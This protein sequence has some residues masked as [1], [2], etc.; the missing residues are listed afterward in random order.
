V[1]DAALAACR[2]FAA[3]QAP[4]PYAPRVPPVSRVLSEY[5]QS[6]GLASKPLVSREDLTSL[7][8]VGSPPASP[9]HYFLRAAVLHHGNDADHGHYRCV[10]RQGLDCW[11]LADDAVVTALGAFP[12]QLVAEEAVLALYEHPPI[13]GRAEEKSVSSSSPDGR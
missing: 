3:F 5:Y 4:A 8:S 10:F 1:A 9:S 2:P 13:A 6:L 7:T 11:C 12:F